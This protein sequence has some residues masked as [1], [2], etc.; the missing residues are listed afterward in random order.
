MSIGA[1][2]R[3]SAPQNS[4]LLAADVLSRLAEIVE[5]VEI[6]GHDQRAI[7]IEDVHCVEAPSKTDL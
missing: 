6:Y 5:V 1:H 3:P 2:S 7:G 4:G